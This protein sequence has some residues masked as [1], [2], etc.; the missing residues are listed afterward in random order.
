MCSASR[1][2]SAAQSAKLLEVKSFWMTSDPRL[3]ARS[4][5]RES[6]GHLGGA[7]FIDAGQRGSDH[8]ADGWPMIE[9][10]SFEEL[11]RAGRVFAK[12]GR[13]QGWVELKN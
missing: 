12:M 7:S 1:V 9:E 11:L 10:R 3:T 4:S 2:K 5:F 6:D 13:R 8:G